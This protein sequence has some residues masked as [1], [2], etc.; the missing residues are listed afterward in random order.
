[1]RLLYLKYILEQPEEA[2]IRK[3]FNLQF[4]KPIR[5]DWVSTC[6]KDIKKLNLKITFEEIKCVKKKQFTQILKEKIKEEALKYLLE[7]RGKKGGEI[8]YSYLEMAEYLLPFNNKLSIDEKREMF[9]VKNAMINIPANFTSKNE[10]KC[11]CGKLEDMQHI[12]ECEQLNN[13]TPEISFRK[14]F[15]GNL[16]QQIEVFKQFAHNMKNREKMKQISYR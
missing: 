15:V 7:K 14:I 10:T 12:Y 4:E 5:G 2:T 3:I 1:M 8:N 13:K 16:R 6:K 11:E 9:A